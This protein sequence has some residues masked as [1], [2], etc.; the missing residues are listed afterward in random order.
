MQ[1]VDSNTVSRIQN[2]V[3]NGR[4]LMSCSN[5]VSI[6]WGEHKFKKTCTVSKYMEKVFWVGRLYIL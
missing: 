4:A 6:A 2:T 1:P 3:P 5:I